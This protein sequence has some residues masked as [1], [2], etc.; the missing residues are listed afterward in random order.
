MATS[1]SALR[2][3]LPTQLKFRTKTMGQETFDEALSTTPHEDP[4][5]ILVPAQKKLSTI[6]SQRVLSVVDETARRLE[7]ALA[8]PSLASSLER[9]SVPLG[10]ELVQLLREYQDIVAELETVSE[11]LHSLGIS[12]R[13]SASGHRSCSS[14]SV[15]SGSSC[16]KL[17]APLDE[18]VEERFYSLQQ[19]IRHNVKSTLRAISANPSLL[20]AVHRDKATITHAQLM[21]SVRG[22][23]SV[24]NE[25]L[26]TTMMEE[27]K[28]KEHLQ[29]VFQRRLAAEETITRL[30]T[31]LAAAQKQKDEEV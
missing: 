18:G 7:V 6:E 2:P 9:L 16:R 31:E 28:R 26:L 27:V 22:L 10:S 5:R 29:V 11:T 23:R 19:R 21:E 3:A 24:S 15:A 13:H 30:E 14:S 12:P 17:L 4:L 20:Q 25:I 8:I 1:K